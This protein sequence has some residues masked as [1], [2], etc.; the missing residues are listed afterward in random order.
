MPVTD[1]VRLRGLDLLRATAIALVLMS[2][3]R[4][5]V[6]H[7]PTFGAIGAIG[8]AGVD[9]F[10]VLSGYLIGNQVLAPIARGERFSLKV[11]FA[12]RLLRTLP[13]YYVVLAV[14]LLVPP[15]FPHSAIVGT[16]TS[17]LW[18]FLTFTQNFGLAYG[19]TFTHSWSLCIEEQF[20]VVMPLAVLALARWAPSA[21]VAWCLLG[22]AVATGV[23][24]RAYAWLAH[25]HGAFAAEV[26]Y[27]SFCRSDELL[28]G[29]A[30]AMLRNFHKGLFTRLLRYGNAL[31]VAGLGM[32][33][34]V[35]VCFSNELPTPFLA[36]ALGFSL[37]AASFALLTC[38][39][40]SPNC[41]LNH[42]RVPG[43]SSL[44]LWSYAVYLAHKPIFMALRPWCERLGVDTE[45]PLSI[46]AIMAMSNFGGWVL[47]R[48]VETPFMSF[49]A[50]WYPAAPA[51]QPP[52]AI[53]AAGP[54]VVPKDAA[55]V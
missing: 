1:T 55:R 37:V 48:L 33:T 47:F 49:R 12:R 42:L 36:S 40:L 15:L 23:G 7:A 54:T 13:N 16:S 43:A 52:A 18:Q 51:H 34:A 20:Y 38:A 3:Y 50:R 9:L 28:F 22:A 46:L 14:Y 17:S 44:A 39:A 30:I 29:V 24:A 19:Q 10:F 26:Y 4:S 5:F 41:L 35:L 32:A 21:R 25:D 11:F 45:A 6:S 2:H 31:L 27:S 53:P 8:W